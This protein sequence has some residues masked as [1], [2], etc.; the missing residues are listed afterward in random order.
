MGR[1]TLGEP[2]RYVADS[3]A[4]RRLL[5]REVERRS[6]AERMRARAEIARETDRFAGRLAYST[7]FWHLEAEPRSYPPSTWPGLESAVRVWGLPA[8]YRFLPLL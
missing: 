7:Q 2:P 6:R 4:V 3:P 1:G 8:G 5:R